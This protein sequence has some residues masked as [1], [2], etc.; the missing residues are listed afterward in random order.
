MR[1]VQT[2]WTGNAPGSQN[3]SIDI[4][5]GW[6]TS[7][8]HWISWALSCLQAC[9][10]FNEVHL[11]TDHFGKEILIDR[12]GLPYSGV[13]TELEGVLR[14]YP[15]Q[16]WALA[17]IF[18]YSIQSEPF[19]HIDG[20]VFLWEKPDKKIM[21]AG[22]ISQNLEKDLFFYK[23]ALD[24]IN[25]VF[26][27]LPPIYQK[28]YYENKTI[29]SG[30]AGLIGGKDLEFFKIYCAEAFAFVD[31]NR[32]DI[33]K[34]DPAN[35]SNLNFLFEQYALVQIA[36]REN[37]NISFYLEEV[38][39]TPV[40]EDLIRFQDRPAV[41]MVHPVGGFKKHVNLCDHL[42]NSLRASY[43]AFYYRIM[44]MVKQAGVPMTNKIYNSPSTGISNPYTVYER[45]GEAKSIWSAGD[46]K[47]DELIAELHHLEQQK[48]RL[49]EKIFAHS[50][51]MSSP[52]KKEALK[53]ESLQ[54]AFSL[55]APEML[56]LLVEVNE[57]VLL[58]ELGWIWQYAERDSIKKL[59]EKNLAEDRSSN[60][61]ALVPSIVRVN[62]YE[63]YMDQ[64]DTLIVET[65][66]SGVYTIESLIE[67]V[68]QYFDPDEIAANPAG[69]EKLVID[70]LKR[71]S[72]AGVL[73]IL[74]ER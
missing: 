49:F 1:I 36:L 15:S 38:I 26:G 24:G 68:K 21:E 20:D 44:E 42:S 6:P 64:L 46:Q 22:I 48:D 53:Y 35:L 39:E 65:I 13:S 61:V 71:L 60:M 29:Y 62:I 12:L 23:A 41:K 18:S 63:Y 47:K 55:G 33:D 51:E 28:G 34:I 56:R 72:Y 58:I 67:E 74:F 11:V 43:P 17:K 8:Y 5:A 3:R 14:D 2:F 4:K 27:D 69:L 73:K 16:L 37:R 66:R 9:S 54:Q 59:L 70:T 19:L 57:N 10:L 31:R 52:Y 50:G 45:T 32:K 30:N 7:E 40:Y 25:E